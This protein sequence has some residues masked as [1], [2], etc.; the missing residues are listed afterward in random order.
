LTRQTPK[1]S[2]HQSDTARARMDSLLCLRGY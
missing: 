2:R 1:V